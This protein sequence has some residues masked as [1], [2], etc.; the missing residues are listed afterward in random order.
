MD[1][2]FCG[3]RLSIAR[4][5]SIEDF[6]R[7]LLGLYDSDSDY[8]ARTRNIRLRLGLYYTV[9]TPSMCMTLRFRPRL[10]DYSIYLHCGYN[11]YSELEPCIQMLVML[12]TVVFSV[13]GVNMCAPFSVLSV[14]YPVRCLG[15]KHV[16]FYVTS[17]AR[18]LAKAL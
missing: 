3:S 9:P 8:T 2:T 15:V 18:F 1:P 4:L 12:L 11:C 14:F 13:T 16:I 10:Y 17:S 7:L 5:L 6:I